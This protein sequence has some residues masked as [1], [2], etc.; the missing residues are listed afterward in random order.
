MRW[1][2]ALVLLC[3]AYV[4]G[5]ALF[6]VAL[7]MPQGMPLIPPQGLVVF[8]GG[9]GRVDAALEV[10]RKGFGG[11]VLISGVHEDVKLHELVPADVVAAIPPE[12][13][14]LDY[15]AHT[16]RENVLNTVNWAAEKGITDIAVVTNRFHALRCRVLFVLLAPH[17]RPTML[18]VADGAGWETL[19]KEYNKLLFAPL[20]M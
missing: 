4:V 15:E 5:F 6:V 20:V 14:T 11:P 9:S 17:M 2:V 12:N 3:V 16:T 8:T 13:L 1:A 10:V 19:W 18:V 7:P